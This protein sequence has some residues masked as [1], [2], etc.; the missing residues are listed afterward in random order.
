MLEAKPISSPM[1]QSKSLS[2]FEGD[3]LLDITM[4]KSTVR[5]LQYLSLT[6]PGISFIVNK[7]SQFM[8]HLTNIQ[9]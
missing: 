5:A 7:L 1:A 8:H 2:T 9:W 3:P 4:Y 6:R